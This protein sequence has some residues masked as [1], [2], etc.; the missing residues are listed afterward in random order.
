MPSG[1]P[2]S[3]TLLLLHGTGGDERDLLP[4]AD[5]FGKNINLLSLRGNVLENGMPRFFKRLE[6]GVFDEQDVKFRAEEMVAFLKS[7]K[8]E[9]FDINNIVALGY[10]NGA[11]IAGAIIMLYPPFLKGAILFRPMKPLSGLREF[12]TNRP[13]PVFVSAGIKD[14]TVNKEDTEE[15]V[16]LLK[17][18]GFQVDSYAIK[19]GHNLSQQDFDLAGKWFKDKFK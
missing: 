11:N 17:E 1:M 9:G 3:I 14:P 12:N 6:M 10:S 2:G 5:F 4:L 19:A 7:F 16:S 8:G 15:Y 13:V 18:N